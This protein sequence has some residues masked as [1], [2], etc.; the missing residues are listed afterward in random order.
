[1]KKPDRLNYD[2]RVSYSQ[3]DLLK[4]LEYKKEK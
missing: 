2:E 4:M 1:M 3:K